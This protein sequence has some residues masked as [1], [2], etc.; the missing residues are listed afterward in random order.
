MSEHQ[1]MHLD[2]N[3][4]TESLG[5]TPGPSPQPLLHSETIINITTAMWESVFNHMARQDATIAKQN[6]TLESLATDLHILQQRH[7]A[8]EREHY[9]LTISK[10]KSSNSEPKIPD[11]PMFKGDRKELLPFLTKCQLKFE[12]QPSQF[13]DDRA[14]VLYA[15]TRLEGTPFSWFQPLIKLWPAAS[16]SSLAPAEIRSWEAFQESLT[17]IYGDP[18]LAATADREIRALKQTGSVSEYAAHFE[19]KK[20]YLTWNDSAFRD[21]FYLNLDKDIK[22][23]MAA[24]GKPETLKGLK[25]LAIRLDTRLEERRLEVRQEQ[26]RPSYSSTRQ[27]GTPRFNAQPT[28]VKTTPAPASPA[29]STAPITPQTG[30]QV[31]SHTADGTVP[32]ELDANGVWRLAA[33]EKDRRKRLGLCDYCAAPD[34]VV[35]KCPVCPPP[36]NRRPRFERRAFMSVEVTPEPSEKALT[37]E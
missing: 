3:E 34:H 4:D 26:G 18:N 30:L 17:S 13:V 20:Q 7:A 22:N 2:S 25:E 27:S 6:E 32:M 1:S 8:L 5:P 15:G 33:S 36:S 21:Q 31:P 16:P 37:Q 28:H 11:P 19:A 10:P 23:N 35:A 12:G 29:T 9:T 24:F 14:K